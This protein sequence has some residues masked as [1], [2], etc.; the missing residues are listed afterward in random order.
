VQFD[1]ASSLT[2]NGKTEYANV[3]FDNFK[4][5]KEEER[6]VLSKYYSSWK[7]SA[8]QVLAKQHE[9]MDANHTKDV[10]PP[11]IPDDDEIPF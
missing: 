2:K 8:Q 3:T 10:T 9:E 4:K 11:T 1:M 6:D 5:V 7:G